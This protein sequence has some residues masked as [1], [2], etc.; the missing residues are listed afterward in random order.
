MNFPNNEIVRYDDGEHYYYNED[1][2]LVKVRDGE[3]YT[4]R[5]EEIWNSFGKPYHI[6]KYK[7][8]M[9]K[10]I[11]SK[12]GSTGLRVTAMVDGIDKV[13][14]ISYNIGID[15]ETEEVYVREVA[16]EDF[17]P[18]ITKLGTGFILKESLLGDYDISLHKIRLSGKGKTIKY[19]IEQVDDKFFGILGFSTVYKE[20]KP[21]IKN[22]K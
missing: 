21:S 14:P 17:V 1:E 9:I 6:K 7:Q 2:E 12:E 22:Y 13:N 18:T 15:D 19:I 3:N 4:T 8:L 10:V 16:N 5:L 11:D 20:K